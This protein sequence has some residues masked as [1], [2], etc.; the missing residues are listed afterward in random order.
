MTRTKRLFIIPAVGVLLALSGCSAEDNLAKEGDAPEVTCER[1]H[2]VIDQFRDVDA[3]DMG[4]GDILALVSE[5]FAE[6]E[7]IA[8]EAQDEE[9]AQSIDTVTETLNSSIA[10]AGGDIDAVGAEF[11]ERLQQQPEAQEAVTHLDEAC[12]LDMPF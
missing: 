11:N 3:E 4:F 7:T 1:L 5:G 8:D 12:G 9:L 6:L 10:S 2:G